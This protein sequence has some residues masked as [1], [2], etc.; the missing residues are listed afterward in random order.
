MVNTLAALC[1]TISE[2]E[3][4]FSWKRVM[5]IL[6]LEITVLVTSVKNIILLILL[7]LQTL[8]CE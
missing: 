3:N 8:N 4:K 6:S 1:N 2:L 7:Y 5:D